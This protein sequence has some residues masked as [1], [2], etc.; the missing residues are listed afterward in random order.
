M[1]INIGSRN[2]NK[3]NAVK[4]AISDFTDWNCEFN[5]LEVDSS[6][7]EEPSS[8]NETIDGAINR[9]K[10]SFKDC[11]YSI[12]LED[13]TMEV[14]HASSGHLNFCACA[15]YDGKNIHV[16]LSPSFEHP[17]KVAKLIFQEGLGLNEAYFKS[18]LTDKPN[19]GSAEGVLGVLTS[20][21]LTREDYTMYSVIMALSHLLNS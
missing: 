6:I 12:G 21:K 15:I 17:P 13:G 5:P 10:N 11:N 14:T 4:R 19:L 20:S 9:A 2:Q 1:I 3:I 8:L 7:S 16:G 18:G